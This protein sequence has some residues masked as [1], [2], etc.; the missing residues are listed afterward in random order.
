MF[1][2]FLILILILLF[3]NKSKSNIYEF[4]VIRTKNSTDSKYIPL[5]ILIDFNIIN[6][7]Y[8]KK[9]SQKIEILKKNII[10][11]K[12]IYESL[13]SVNYQYHIFTPHFNLGKLC[14]NEIF[15]N[16]R[17]IGFFTNLII[18]PLFGKNETYSEHL[19]NYHICG[20]NI[21]DRKPLIA[22]LI[23]SEKILNLEEEQIFLEIIHS[24]FHIL[25]FRQ[26]SREKA[27][28]KNFCSGNSIE[29]LELKKVAKKYNGVYSS[30]ISL[31]NKGKNFLHWT[32]S[33]K[34]DIMPHKNFRILTFNEYSLRYLQI[35]KWYR[36]NMN[37]CGCSL[38]GDCNFGVLPYEIY[39]NKDTLSLYCYR[40]DIFNKKCIINNNIFF[41]SL[42][43]YK[44]TNINN[45]RNYFINEKCRNYDILYDFN[46][47]LLYKGLIN[48]QNFSEQEI[49]LISPVNKPYCKCHLK[50]IFLYNKFNKEYN[51]YIENNFDLQKIKIS[52]LNKVVY[53]SFTTYNR[54]HS[55]SFR[56]TLEYNNIV[57]LNN[58]YSPNILFSLLNKNISLELLSHLNKYTII[59]NS[60]ILYLLGHKE[61]TYKLYSKFKEKFPFDFDYMVE[62]YIMPKQKNIVEKKFKNY[63][64]KENDLWLCKPSDGSFGEGIYFLKNY[65]D[66]LNCNQLISKY[67]HNPHLYK[68]RK[69]HLRLYNFISSLI[70]LKI[71][72]YKEGQVM[73]AS[74]EYKYKLNNISDKQSF[75]TNAHINFGKDGYIEDLSLKDLKEEITKQG[76]N[77]K[78]IW[79]Q[80]KDICI[81][82]II[83]IYD[84]EYNKLKIFTKNEAKSFMFFGLD[85]MIDE[86]Y[87]VWFLEAND[88]AHMVGYDKINE[89]NKIGI[90][91]DILNILGII[92]FDH[93]NN[94][95]L[96]NKTCNFKNQF[97]QILNNAFCEFYRPQGNL[98]RIFPVK[99][100]LSYYKK[101]FEKKYKEN[102]ELW[103]Y[104]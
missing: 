85:M 71:Y 29:N 49:V 63:I 7:Y 96:E 38:N 57:L 54:K 14:Q 55:E 101:F 103:N 4:E 72:L 74:H 45:K 90:S 100:S 17:A 25:G 93:S 102:I 99:E 98:E 46:E 51:K 81:K 22:T 79:S 47:N 26:N 91:T 104:L 3:V 11:A 70:P 68:K 40:N 6:K 9:N 16:F 59:R 77:W 12:S 52:D 42:K 82:I 13:I 76:G 27:G 66:F 44:D 33:I 18:F 24:L 21:K 78:L 32:E 69:Y 20:I 31:F 92:P 67:I 8:H 36:V 10:K 62:S 2:N 80:I 75:L 28:I 60:Q 87:K 19:I 39:I 88:A 73:R 84:E 48:K 86:N 37:I 41:F 61:Y 43:K 95:P 23:I 65:Q 15:S 1:K 56:D 97:E 5:S 50:T 64:Q 35:L 53:G 94:N 30:E 34:Y 83:T 58:E 89:I